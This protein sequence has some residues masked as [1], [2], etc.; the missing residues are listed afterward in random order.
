MLVL[1]RKPGE[2]IRVGKDVL[3]TIVRQGPSGVRVGID[4][5]KGVNIVRTELEDAEMKPRPQS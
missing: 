3:I 2:K 1:S 4:A 5:P